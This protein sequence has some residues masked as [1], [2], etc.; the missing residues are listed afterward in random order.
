MAVGM[1]SVDT[2]R[3]KIEDR[4]DKRKRLEKALAR[5]PIPAVRGADGDLYMIDHHHFGLA[6][7]QADIEV[8]YVQIIEDLSSLS[9]SSFWRQMEADGR[10]YPFDEDGRR[11]AHDN[12][13]KRLHGL[14]DDPYR[15]LAWEVRQAGGYKKTRVPYAE[16]QWANLF[17]E[18]IKPAPVRRKRTSAFDRAMKLCRSLEASGLPGFIPAN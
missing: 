11:V 6:L 17:R 4:A 9:W 13:P 18:H 3:R 5:R 7:W 12:L 16:F 15:D 2:K 14:R 10:V 8:A 1:R